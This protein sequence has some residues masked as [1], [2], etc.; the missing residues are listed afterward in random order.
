MVGL[1]R[2]T[3]TLGGWSQSG[4]LAC[5][6][7]SGLLLVAFV[8]VEGVSPATR[9]G[10]I[11]FPPPDFCR[12]RDSGL[13]L[14]EAVL[15]PFIF[16]VLSLSYNLGYSTLSIGGH[17]FLLS[18][19]T[20]ALLPLAGWLDRF[21]P[22]RLIICAGLALVG[23]GLWLMSRLPAGA[24]WGDLVPGLIIAGVGLE[25]VNPRLAYTAAAA[26][27]AGQARS[28]VPRGPI[29]PFATWARR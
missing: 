28:A 3:T 15:G 27:A 19:M 5:F 26:A 24:D 2:T 25:L 20:I 7:C 4:V 14:V 11:P 18:G 1:I 16:L 13:R 10:R 29:P 21:V 17:L 6:A 9:S 22:V 12:E 23:A 8:A